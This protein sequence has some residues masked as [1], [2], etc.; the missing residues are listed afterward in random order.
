MAISLTPQ[1]QNAV[2]ANGKVLVSAAAGSGKTAVLVERVMRRFCD[3]NEP[4]MADRAL[5]VTFTNAAATELKIKIESKLQQMLL[6]N[7]NDFLLRRQSMLI[8]SAK[9][10]T[11]DSFCISLVK[12]YFNLLDISSDFKT[13]DATEL[14][15]DYEEIL[16]NLFKEKHNSSDE[17]FMY[18]L[19][20]LQ[21]G[22]DDYYLKEIVYSIYNKS[23]SMPYQSKWLDSLVFQYKEAA[24][25]FDNS[26]WAN[27]IFES[28]KRDAEKAFL[29]ATN[30][31]SEAVNDDKFFEKYEVQLSTR[32][33]FANT[34][35]E[36][37]CK[38]DWDGVYTALKSYSS[39]SLRK[40]ST[41]NSVI[42]DAIAT[43]KN[44][45]NNLVKVLNDSF[46]F[47]R[48]TVIKSLQIFATIIEYVSELVKEYINRIYENSLQKNVFTFDQIEHMALKLLTENGDIVTENFNLN[49]DA[50]LVDEYQDTNN[51][52]D[53]IFNILSAQK[54]EL[55]MVGDVKQSIYGFRNANPDNFLNRKD[56]Y[57]DYSKTSKNSKVLL[58]GNFRSRKGVCDFVNYLFSAYMTKSDADM[59]Y[60]EEEALTPLGSY[61]E[62]SEPEVEV[63][64]TE[65][66]EEQNNSS[67]EA[68]LIADYIEATLKKEPF[69]RAE[70]GGLRKAE[71][72]DFCILMRSPKNKI[73]H[74]VEVFKNR[75]IPVS[76]PS[77]KFSEASE[78][79]GAMSLLKAINN[80]NDS[81]SLASLLKT[82]V[83]NFNEE[84]IAIMRIQNK[85]VPLYLN[86]KSSAE[87]G[88]QKAEKAYNFLNYASRLSATLPVHKLLNRLF[89]E[90]GFVEI[91]SSLN[92]GEMRKANLRLLVEKAE[93]YDYADNGIAEFVKFIESDSNTAL[94]ANIITSDKSVQIM[95]VHNS[96][97]LQF[98]ICIICGL[99][100]KF[101]LSDL[102]NKVI[103][104]D[105]LGIAFNY[106]D[107]KLGST[108]A[109]ISKVAIKK[110]SI[111]KTYKEELRLLYVALTRAC[112]KL[113]LVSSVNKIES[114]LEKV[115]E[116][117]GLNAKNTLPFNKNALFN[118][119]SY[120]EWIFSALICH[121]NGNHLK[122]GEKYIPIVNNNCKFNV[123]LYELKE[124]SN[125]N[126]KSETTLNDE[127]KYDLKFEYEYPHKRLNVVPAKTSVTDI[128]GSSSSAQLVFSGKPKFMYEGGYT[129]ADVG[130]ATHKF[131]EY[132]DY[133][134]A[135]ID[136]DAEINRLYEWQYITLEESEIIDKESVKAFFESEIYLLSLKAKNT[137]KE[138]RFLTKVNANEIIEDIT[139]D[140]EF[141]VVQGVA[142][143]IIE[144]E[145][146]II[147]IDFK[148]DKIK[149]E[150][151]LKS[152]YTK[153]LNLYA[154][155]LGG[156]FNKPVSK[157]IIYSFHLRKYIEL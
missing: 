135:T 101:N 127:F 123:S 19:D 109:P 155:A 49:Y 57:P 112:E 129:S 132:C 46:E 77:Q 35:L 82:P 62:N 79:I 143:C 93:A 152:R 141:S 139:D 20:T 157:K 53:E 17:H 64:L 27:L 148:T 117:A 113:V 154:N 55:F 114:F 22:Y 133:A 103:I 43:S 145:N 29:E 87:N 85:Y 126:E 33:N 115:T 156:I 9:I 106:N 120:A 147:I 54:G 30:L 51:L 75:G 104:D 2:D 80:F 70:D 121:K 11:I 10:C 37:L 153:Q 3:Q 23:C 45:E 108:I 130:T 95:S 13:T 66:N 150:N 96:K 25:D 69:L 7:P 105:K 89:S 31:K 122:R 110:G 42:S 144:N 86:L 134:T 78:I 97:G 39:D 58:S 8:K 28:L 72:N 44:A 137:Y 59:D 67:A 32:V 48:K 74:Y 63:Y 73:K 100:S 38:R 140:N 15:K 136:I 16:E 128:L 56:T 12:E 1:Q 142:D 71:L 102:N 41:K 83:F 68:N 40:N 47:D 90:S 107:L 36:S 118:S 61:P 65:P 111:N 18:L 98:P 91:Y 149:D 119:S 60:S 14:S 50:I 125:V 124:A 5:I 94:S 6:E 88:N 116:I 81:L 99:N 84:E 34:I 76:T 92:G 131:M 146:D 26:Q 4:L 21:S 52:Q 24:I 138:Y 151:V